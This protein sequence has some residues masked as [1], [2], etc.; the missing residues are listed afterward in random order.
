MDDQPKYYTASEK[1]LQAQETANVL[2][3]KLSFNEDR[4]IFL[5]VSRSFF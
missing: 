2:K 5:G 3:M 1:T 4:N